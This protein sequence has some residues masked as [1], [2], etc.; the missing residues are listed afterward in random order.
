MWFGSPT[1]KLKPHNTIK[2][3]VSLEGQW[4]GEPRGQGGEK[5]GKKSLLPTLVG[6]GVYRKE[7]RDEQNQEGKQP[8]SSMGRVRKFRGPGHRLRT[9]LCPFWCRSNSKCVKRFCFFPNV[10]SDFEIFLIRH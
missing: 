8:K 5:R 1:R 9:Q 2:A 3:L 7:A 10:D 4:D 6:K